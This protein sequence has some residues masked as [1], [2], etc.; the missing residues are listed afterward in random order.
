[1][2][3][4][5]I[6]KSSLKSNNVGNVKGVTKR[7]EVLNVL[8]SGNVDNVRNDL[9]EE[10]RRLLAEKGLNVEYILNKY[11]EISGYELKSVRASDV[12][13]VLERL[14]H[15]HG[16]DDNNANNVDNVSIMLQSKTLEEVKTFILSI[17]GKTQ[18]YLARLERSKSKE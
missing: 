1:M 3:K 11:K 6:V 14:E 2:S 8:E 4:L 10:T 9:K 13:K 12:L 5:Q 7:V 17:S 15:L 16:L 18:E